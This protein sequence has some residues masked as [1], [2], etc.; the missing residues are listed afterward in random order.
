MRRFLIML[1]LAAPTGLAAQPY[2][3]SMADCAALY[4]NAAQW[5]RPHLVDRLMYA[6]VQWHGA[7]VSR[8]H[9]EGQPVSDD[10]MWD[11]V[12]AQ[13]AIWEAEGAAFIMSQEF[14]DWTAYCRSFARQVNVAYE[15]PDG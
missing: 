9:S 1:T 3:A 13:T 7:A 8:S 11:R 5:V 15:M 6:A 2:S 4:Q 10:Q 14:R 12:N